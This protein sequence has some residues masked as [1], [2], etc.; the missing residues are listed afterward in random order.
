MRFVW[1]LFGGLLFLFGSWGV[2]ALQDPFLVYGAVKYEDGVAASGA[3][4]VVSVN[5]VSERLVSD[6]E[7]KFSV[8]LEEYKDGDSV[9]VSASLRGVSVNGSGVVDVSTG[10][11]QVDLM[12]PGKAPADAS[13][14]SGENSMKDSKGLSGVSVLFLLFSV[15]AA[16]I[17]QMRVQK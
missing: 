1:L 3:D 10:G 11:L 9:L 2:S 7:G 17:V 6:A 5:G 4:V 12:L 8:V 14:V 13:S 16:V 15:F